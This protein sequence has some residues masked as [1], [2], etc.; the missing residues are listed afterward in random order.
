MCPY[1]ARVVEIGSRRRCLAIAGLVA[2]ALA[3]GACA[4]QR[5][6]IGTDTELGARLGFIRDLDCRRQLVETRLGEPTS[7]F[8]NGRVVSY[9]VYGNRDGLSLSSVGGDCFGL[10]IE[11]DGD[12]RV[13]R[14]AL[15][16]HGSASCRKD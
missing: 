8:E 12:G 10:M 4:M 13:S 3:L 14:F 6:V 15:I 11:Y 2:L 1:T 16:R 9:A 5:E 7:S